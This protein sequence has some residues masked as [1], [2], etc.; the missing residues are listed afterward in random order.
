MAAALAVFVKT[1]ARSPVKTRLVATLGRQTAH[2]IY[3]ESLRLLRLQLTLAA[4]AGVAVHWAVAEK[5]AVTDSCWNDFP[6][7]WT[8]EGSLGQRLHQVYDKLRGSNNRVILIGADCPQLPATV[9]LQAATASGTVIG[10]ARDG[11]FYLF[12]SS[13]PV[14]R[15][16]WLTPQYSSPT[17]LTALLAVLA[18]KDITFLPTLTDIDDTQSLEHCLKEFADADTQTLRRLADSKQLST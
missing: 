7:L 1:A 17:T 8:G 6:A 10:P 4:A 5:D 2:A 3:E 9:I 12:A 18:E 16:Q 15:Q 14:T 11:G 13:N